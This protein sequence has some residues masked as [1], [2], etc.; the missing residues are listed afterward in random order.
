MAHI[1]SDSHRQAMPIC[2]KRLENI[3]GKGICFLQVFS[4]FPTLFL[5]AFFLMLTDYRSSGLRGLQSGKRLPSI[6]ETFRIVF[7]N[8]CTLK[9]IMWEGEK[10]HV[11]CKV[12]FSSFYPPSRVG[13]IKKMIYGR[14]NWTRKKLNRTQLFQWYW[15]PGTQ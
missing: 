13:F 2:L 5:K 14:K 11:K 4:H 8:C 3:I 15:V 7:Q 1:S 10:N 12:F 9:M 6:K